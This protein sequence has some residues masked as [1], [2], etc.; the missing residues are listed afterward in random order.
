MEDLRLLYSISDF[1]W[2]IFN[3]DLLIQAMQILVRT[4]SGMQTAFHRT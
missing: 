1:K 3:Y 2:L 4:Q